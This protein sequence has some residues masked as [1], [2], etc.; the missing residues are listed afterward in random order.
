MESLIDNR[1]IM[2]S[3]WD[4]LIVLDACRFDYFKKSYEEYFGNVELKKVY[5]CFS[6]TIG[7]LTGLF[8]GKYYDD[9]VYISSNVFVN[10]KTEVKH[11]GKKFSGKEH[12]YNV[13]DVWD[14]G[15]N[16]KLGTVHPKKINE[17][18]FNSV[19]KYP[20]KRLI[21]HYMQ[22][23]YPYISEGGKSDYT[24]NLK[25]CLTY[26]RKLKNEIIGK[27]LKIAKFFISDEIM[28]KIEGFFRLPSPKLKQMVLNL[29]KDGIRNAYENDLKLVLKYVKELTDKVPGKYLITADHGEMLGES[30][31]WGHGYNYKQCREIPW[32]LVKSKGSKKSDYKKTLK[33]N[34]KN[35]NIEEK[36]KERLESFGYLD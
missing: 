1:K 2:D 4:Y 20:N 31:R 9:V 34:R 3:N 21:I 30:G 11:R 33:K 5:S 32:L 19:K 16:K 15:W 13:I 28:W 27:I 6:D 14:W 29:G 10:S 23:H 17:A 36:I 8:K 12:F 35:K 18:F 25:K 24:M 7:F 22:P 26:K